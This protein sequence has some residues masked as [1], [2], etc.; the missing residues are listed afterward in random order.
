LQVFRS[1]ERG[2]LPAVEELLEKNNLVVYT[3]WL[4]W[5]DCDKCGKNAQ[6]TRVGDCKVKVNFRPV[7]IN[8]ENYE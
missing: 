4:E 6:R 2:P 1:S 7:G 8:Q 3:D 5:G